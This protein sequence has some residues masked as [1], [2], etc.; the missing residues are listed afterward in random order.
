M[1]LS[2]P[3]NSEIK[4]LQKLLK[5]SRIRRENNRFVIEGEREILRAIE[6]GY[7]IESFFKIKGASIDKETEA[8]INQTNANQYIV[9]SSLWHRIAMRSG[10]EKLV[11]LAV[12]KKHDLN[13]LSLSSNSIIMV[14]EAAEK[15]GNIGAILRTAAGLELDAVILSNTKTDLYNPN[16][17][18][19][20]LGGIFFIPIGLATSE[21]ILKFL[22]KQKVNIITA[23]LNENA[24]QSPLFVYELPCALVMGSEDKGVSQLWME[25]SDHIVEIP[26][27]KNID[28]LNLSVSAGILM[29]DALKQNGRLKDSL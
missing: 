24:Q 27:S 1:L 12:Q 19:S 5:K 4:H 18:R 2:S 22:R 20:S 17:I 16:L 25:N 13:S 15:P 8:A 6:A 21:D 29:Y 23:A 14:V 3:Q 9:I 10:T 11:A 28:S 7:T 26:M